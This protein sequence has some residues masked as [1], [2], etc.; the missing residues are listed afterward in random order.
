MDWIEDVLIRPLGDA[1]LTVSFGQ[2]ID[3]AINDR[4]HLLHC[5]LAENP[6]VGIVETVPTYCSLVVLYRPDVLCWAAI[7]EALRLRLRNMGQEAPSSVEDTVDIPVLYGGEE[8]PDLHF[9][10]QH[11]GLCEDEVIRI[12]SQG[13]YRIYMLGFSPGFPYLGG[14]D[15]RIA[16]PRLEVPRVCIPAGSVGIAGEQTGVYP[17]ASP[18]GWRLI[19]RTPRKLYHP[20]RPKPILLHAGCKLRFRPINREEYDRIAREEETY[21]LSR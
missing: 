9:V 18:G 6:I 2:A 16:A 4:V 14:L 8:G 15:S 7:C 19:G 1:A 21:G 5:A 20:D 11:A 10:A 3:P 17:L 12:H 13:I